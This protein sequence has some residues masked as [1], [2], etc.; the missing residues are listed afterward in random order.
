MAEFAGS[1]VTLERRDPAMMVPGLRP[2]WTLGVWEPSCAYIDVAALHAAMLTTARRHGAVLR[3]SAGLQA[4]VRDQA[5][6]RID[7][8]DGSI[9]ARVLVDAAGAW[10]DNV[11]ARRR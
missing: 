11:A 7:T 9:E 1:P 6:W 4:A 10:A 8:G 2:G 5:R 3:T